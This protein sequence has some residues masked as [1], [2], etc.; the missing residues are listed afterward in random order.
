MNDTNA[1][2]NRPQIKQNAGFVR[3]KM[4]N[5]RIEKS[6][7][8][9]LLIFLAH[10]LVYLTT[11]WAIVL[12]PFW[13]VKVAAILVNGLFIGTFFVVGHDA[14][15]GSFVRQKWLN[16][17]LG[18]LS[19]TPSLN[20]FTAWEVSHNQFHHGYTNFK[21]NDVYVPLT[22]KEYEALSDWGKLVQRFYRTPIGIIFY[23]QIEVW[24][25]QLIFPTKHNR[26]RMNF[27]IF[28]FDLGLMISYVGL[29]IFVL[30]WFSPIFANY[31]QVPQQPFLLNLLL[32][33]ILP[34][35]VWITLYVY[36]TF[37]QHTHP[38][39]AWFDK[40]D[41]WN[42]FRG[43]V[44]GSVHILTSGLLRIV[45]N[46]VLEHAAHHVDVR[47]PLYNLRESQSA[48]KTEFPKAI[49]TQKGIF[50]AAFRTL[51]VCKLYDYDNHCWTD[52]EGNV[53]SKI[54]FVK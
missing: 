3:A 44:E 41:E 43:Q 11:F 49:R 29:K 51:K 16:Q 1:R 38:Q 33:I 5:D 18:R 13:M 23:Y 48:L 42:F 21:Q 26:E 14:C 7:A 19:L 6:T 9:A 24:W 15:H 47:I 27:N 36:I 30:Y 45:T 50:L 22:K 8:K 54:E 28:L 32:A 20:P 35:T 17:L 12:V 34:F 37:L 2:S 53:T 52:F 25:K 46:N 4:P 10:A 39:V 31:F 40:K